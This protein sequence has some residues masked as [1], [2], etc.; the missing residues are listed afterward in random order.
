[1]TLS[2]EAGGTSA[3]VRSRRVSKRSRA[4]PGDT[5]MVGVKLPPFSDSTYLLREGSGRG[6]GWLLGRRLPYSSYCIDC[7]SMSPS[8]KTGRGNSVKVIWQD[9]GPLL[10]VK[11]GSTVYKNNTCVCKYYNV[12][13]QH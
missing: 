1:M 9:D 2:R 6:R 11:R 4:S 12:G 8:A 13:L 7:H 5:I 3:R 10:P